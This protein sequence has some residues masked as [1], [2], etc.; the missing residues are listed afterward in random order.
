MKLKTLLA[1]ALMSLGMFAVGS[2]QAVGIV[3]S[4]GFS[5]G[6]EAASLG[7]TVNIVS[8]LTQVDDSPGPNDT[9]SGCTGT[10]LSEATCT[11]GLGNY[12]FDFSLL[13][14]PQLV[15]SIDGFTFTIN[16]Y[17]LP[18]TR[19]PL[20]CNSGLCGDQLLFT[21]IGTVTGNGY[22]PSI[23]LINW[24]AT[25]NCKQAASGGNL[26]G[27]DIVGT[28]NVTITAIGPRQV[29]E[30][31]TLALMGLGLALL[32]FSTRRRKA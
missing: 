25:G 10:F 8:Q 3:G 19:N 32:G 26:C 18:F 16:S 23:F 29:P 12:A 15:Y 2:A 22:D 7:Q 17:N 5:D 21:G 14:V 24:S 9:A 28:W 1:A 6:L 13:S 31:G 4:I 30:P 11:P 27:S 20:V